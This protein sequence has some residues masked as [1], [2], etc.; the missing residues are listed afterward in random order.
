MMWIA[1]AL[2]MATLPAMA[3]QPTQ[4]QRDAV[5]SACRSDFLKNCSG[6]PRGGREAL[7]CLRDNKAKLSAA[8]DQAISAI[9]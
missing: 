8:C 4:A 9:P 3:Q 5:R 6:V 1:V 2:L 7:Q